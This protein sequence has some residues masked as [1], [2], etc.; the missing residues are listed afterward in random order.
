M[1]TSLRLTNSLNRR[2]YERIRTMESGNV[3]G[4]SASSFDPLCN[5]IGGS[6]FR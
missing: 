4:V 2:C 3:N 1:G 5:S 6:F